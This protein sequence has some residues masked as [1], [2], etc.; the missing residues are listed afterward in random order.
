[1]SSKDLIMAGRLSD[2]RS[3]LIEEVKSS[4]A[5]LGK[6]TLLFQTLAFCGE[7]EKAERHLDVLAAQ[8]PAAETGMQVY[9]NL[10][11]AEKKRME[12]L[13]LN[14]RPSCLPKPPPYLEMYYAAWNKLV[15]KETD[16]AIELFAQIDSQRP[17]ISGTVNGKDFIGFKN[18]D[19]FLSLFL[20]AIEYEHY[21]WIPFESIR[22][23][24]I[25]SPKTL[26]DLLWIAARITTWEGLSMGCYLPVLYPESFL[27][28]DDRVKLGR[29]TD[30]TSLGG[31]YSRG[32]GQHVFQ[33]GEEEMP[34]LEIREVLFKAYD[35]AGN[36]EKSD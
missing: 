13:R 2:A 1:V 12:V 26:F 33:I 3:Q 32:F 22:E 14:S 16:Q 11:L 27:H 31:P 9:K 28:G 34:I 7:W 25:S 36:N 24:S 10:I 19:A 15:E 23:I 18:T 5:D 6:R 21:V 29:V 20:E 17:I 8:D 30:W 4:P 35:P